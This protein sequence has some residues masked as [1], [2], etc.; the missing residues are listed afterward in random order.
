MGHAHGGVRGVNRSNELGGEFGSTDVGIA[1]QYVPLKQATQSPP[2]TH[3][4]CGY[5]VSAL[6]HAHARMSGQ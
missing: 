3:L 2:A 1:N 6:H 5:T 4:R